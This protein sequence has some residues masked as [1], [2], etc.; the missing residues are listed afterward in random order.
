[1]GAIVNVVSWNIPRKHHDDM[2]KLIAGGIEHHTGNDYQRK[3]PDEFFYSRT[4]TF[5]RVDEESDTEEWFFMD[6]YDDVEL[7]HKM[8]ARWSGPDASNDPITVEVLTRNH[9]KFRTLTS[10]GGMPTAKVY[11]VIEPLTLE[12]EP[13]ARREA[14]L[15]RDTDKWWQ[16]EG[17]ED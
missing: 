8:T 5:Y 13:W 1:M 2:V 9:P 6:E 17:I 12:F 15:A 3:H 4:R 10:D 7:L 11:D 14:A 16:L